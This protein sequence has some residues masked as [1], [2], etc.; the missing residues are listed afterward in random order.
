MR[1]F[2]IAGGSVPGTEH[3]KPGQPGWVNNQDAFVFMHTDN[4]LIAIVA[5]GC[6]SGAYSEAGA[7]LGSMLTVNIL[8]ELLENGLTVSEKS[9]P[10]IFDFLK[11]KTVQVISSLAQN[12]EGASNFEDIIENHFLFTLVGVVMDAHSTAIF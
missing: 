10:I 7:R 6:G 1:E 3:T 5:D 12:M 9:L 11:R 4:N 2:G 8:A